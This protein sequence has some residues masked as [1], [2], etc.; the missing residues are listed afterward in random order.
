[1]H[2]SWSISCKLCVT[3]KRTISKIGA[4]KTSDAT[5][6]EQ[7]GCVYFWID[8]PVFHLENGK[9]K[10]QTTTVSTMLTKAKLF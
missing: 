8:S 5:G 1:M 7:T 10:I 6:T 9:R 2:L 4:K 3:I